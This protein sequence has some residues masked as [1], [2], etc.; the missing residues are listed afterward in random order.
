M[1]ET[2]KR[3]RQD[4]YPAFLVLFSF[5]PF[6]VIGSILDVLLAH[7]YGRFGGNETAAVPL[8][9][10]W[11]IDAMAGYR[12]LAQE[13]MVVLWALLVLFF[14]INTLSAGDQAQRKMRFLFGFSFMW[15]LCLTIAS[16]IAFS[17]V[18]PFDLMLDRPD[19]L[20]LLGRIVRFILISEVVLMIIVPIWLG[21]RGKSKNRRR[22]PS[23]SA[24]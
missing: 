20:G 5:V 8:I 18:L 13:I 23:R 17:C 1:G 16:I 9:S 14:L 2:L 10:H 4:V 7:L 6:F 15:L 12:F 11:T 24:G 3:L 19:A 22:G 21:I